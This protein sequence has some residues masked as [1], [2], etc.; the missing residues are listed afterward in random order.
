MPAMKWFFH[1]CIAPSVAFFL[2]M[3]GGVYWISVCWFLMKSLIV[4]VVSLSILWN[5]GLK[6]LKERKLYHFE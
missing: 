2:C 1:V 5:L 6:P 3:S 4:R